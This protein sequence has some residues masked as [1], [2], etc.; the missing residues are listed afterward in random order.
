MGGGFGTLIGGVIAHHYGWRVAMM[1]IGLPGVILA[2]VVWRFVVEPRRGL[3]DLRQVTPEAM[4]SLWQGVLSIWRSH[5]ARHVVMG[6]TITSM[7]GY[8]LV[9]WGPA[10]LQRSLGMSMLQVSLYV[11]IPAAITASASALIGGKL[12]DRMTRR[13][14]SW[15]QAW[16]VAVMKVIAFPFAVAF[17]V[18]DGLPQ[19]LTVY[20]VSLLFAS[21]YLGPSFALVQHLAPLR[22]RALWAAIALFVNNLIGMG[23]G[24]LMVGRLSDWL[25]PT[26]GAD[27]L[28]YA[29]LCVALLTP[30]AIFHY[31]RAGVL[32]RRL[33]A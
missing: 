5:A 32:M 33:P 9:G 27:S 10:Y 2:L 21:A 18:V 14:G 22:L 11:A 23:V 1:A 19:A 30:W 13:H 3:S 29:M 26:Y 7:I 12:A 20:F 25:R 31:W 17:Y 15:A 16:V 24:P 6:F 28:R 8:A 4:P